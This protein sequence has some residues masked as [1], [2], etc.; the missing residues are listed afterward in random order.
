[1]LILQVEALQNNVINKTVNGFEIT[2]NLNR[3]IG[4]SIYFEN[5]YNQVEMATADAEAL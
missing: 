3:I 5:C 1:M 4:E 2:P